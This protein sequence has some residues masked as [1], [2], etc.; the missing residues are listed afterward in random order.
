[1]GKWSAVLC[2]RPILILEGVE[3]YVFMH[4]PHDLRIL[5]PIDWSFFLIMIGILF[6][7][8]EILLG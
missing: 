7:F 8:H 6:S 1:M 4:G 3:F 2:T 5:M